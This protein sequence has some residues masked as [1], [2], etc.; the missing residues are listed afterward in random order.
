SHALA[1]SGRIAEALPLAEQ[2]IEQSARIDFVSGRSL[3]LSLLGEAY[4]MGVQHDRA[5]AIARE[6]LELARHYSERGHEGWALRFHGEI[7]A[8][9]DPPDGAQ[10]ESY[11]RQALALAEELRMRPLVAHCHVGLGM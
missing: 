7:A 4:R 9:A 8:H 10:A 11:Y 3:S 1:L 6:A 5:F 2:A